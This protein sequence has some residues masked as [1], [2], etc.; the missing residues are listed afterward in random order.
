MGVSFR[1]PLT[2]FPF[3]SSLWLR[4]NEPEAAKKH[5]A[6]LPRRDELKRLKRELCQKF[7]LADVR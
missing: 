5:R 3:P 2:V 7:A 1:R 6:S 4:N